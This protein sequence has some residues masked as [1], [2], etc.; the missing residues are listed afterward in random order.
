M[1]ATVPDTLPL[2]FTSPLPAPDAAESRKR[3]AECSIEQLHADLKRI[4]ATTCMTIKAEELSKWFSKTSFGC[5][6]GP[7][8]RMVELICDPSGKCENDCSYCYVR[9]YF[10]GKVTPS[11]V[12]TAQPA[13]IIQHVLRLAYNMAR[14][15]EQLRAKGTWNGLEPELHFAISSDALQNNPAV[16]ERLYTILNTWLNI[17][18]VEVHT[19]GR[20]L[21]TVQ[22][23]LLASIV[24]K[25][26]PYS[27]DMR[28][29]LLA[30]FRE[31]PD[32]ISYQ[33]TCASLD[34]AKQKRVERGAPDP[35]ARL[36]WLAQVAK[37]V[38]EG[39]ALKG[40]KDVAPRVS[41]RMNPMIPGFN[42]SHELMEAIIDRAAAYHIPVAAMSDL[43]LT[44]TISRNMRN[45]ASLDIE[46][47]GAYE[48]TKT[49]LNGGT[50]KFHS[51]PASRLEKFRYLQAY[52]AR[53]KYDIRLVSCGCDNQDV[54]ELASQKCGI[55]WNSFFAPD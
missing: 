21:V 15:M 53:K 47:L 36:V 38:R 49:A 55:C 3:P 45:L 40:K 19:K 20:H 16:Q 10:G 39:L 34:R 52:I 22:V 46:D 31:H 8:V 54:P 33:G 13:D 32:Q 9:N 48:T 11:L 12:S 41:L 44:S 51:S 28:Q 25:G 26:V 6:S 42:D 18:S 35:D 14:R 4:K 5:M 43:Y 27:D 24:S 50:G 37:A 17:E 30:L 2:P 29:R 1:A 7:L 23:R